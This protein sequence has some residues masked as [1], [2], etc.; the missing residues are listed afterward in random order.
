MILYVF[1]DLDH[2]FPTPRTSWLQLANNN[3]GT[4]W[5][6]SFAGTRWTTGK[7]NKPR[8]IRFFFFFSARPRCELLRMGKRTLPYQVTHH[9]VCNRLPVTLKNGIIPFCTLRV[10]PN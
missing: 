10:H 4:I 2:R 1:K 3:L 6:S 5:M 9:C 8:R 7:M